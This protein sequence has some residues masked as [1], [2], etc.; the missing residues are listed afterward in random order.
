MKN[1][2][3]LM[4]LTWKSTFASNELRIFRG[5]LIAGILKTN[6]WKADA[7]GELNGHMLTFKA[8]G[9]WN[10][11]TKILDIEGK[12]ELGE[13][14]Y[15]FWK[16]TAEITYSGQSYQFRYKSWT[17]RKWEVTG[18]EVSA[19]FESKGFWSPEGIVT[20]EDMPGAIIL[21]ALYAHSYFTRINASAT[22]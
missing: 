18:P 3:T 21:C 6:T 9:F 2:C 4:T 10:R 13:I 15:D 19:V 12:T 5:K 8:L 14:S 20:Y 11:G 22:T 1:L 7:Y 16:Q 17:H